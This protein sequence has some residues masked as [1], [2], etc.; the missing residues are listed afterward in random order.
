MI[1]SQ[2]AMTDNDSKVRKKP[3]NDPNGVQNVFIGSVDSLDDAVSS[4]SEVA[5]DNSSRNL[6]NK[7][8][9]I[10]Q[11]QPTRIEQPV[12]TRRTIHRGGALSPAK[13][14]Q[15]L[16]QRSTA[17]FAFYENI[18]PPSRQYYHHFL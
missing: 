12:W 17:G 4:L 7:R 10:D 15:L 16:L 8:D 9:M 1:R 11:E 13:S 2:A 18:T 3:T 5:Y 6:L 14:L